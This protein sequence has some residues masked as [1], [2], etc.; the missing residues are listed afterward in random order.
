[1]YAPLTPFEH[2]EAERYSAFD[3]YNF[4]TKDETLGYKI[5]ETI[6]CGYLEHKPTRTNIAV[7]HKIGWF[8]KYMLN[9][10]F[11]LKYKSNKK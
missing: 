10:C 6:P 8:K 4:V 1:M 7:F 2:E 3:N 9:I 11:G 5:T